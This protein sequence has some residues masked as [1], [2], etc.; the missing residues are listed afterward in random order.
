ME[1]KFI[2]IEYYSLYEDWQIC[3]LTKSIEG[4]YLC[5]ECLICEEEDE[6]ETYEKGNLKIIINGDD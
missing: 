2:E 3:Q 4:F 1:S 5:N 6:H